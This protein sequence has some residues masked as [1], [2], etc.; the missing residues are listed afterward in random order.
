MSE[1]EPKRVAPMRIGIYGGA[2]DPPHLAHLALAQ[3]AVQQ[4]ELDQL[5]ALPTGHAWHKSRTLTLP[6]HRIAMVRLAFAELEQ[7]RVD[8]R[9][10]QRS[11][12][13]YTLDTLLA[14]KAE[15]PG[16]ELFLLMGG[17]QLAA[18]PHWHRYEEILQIAT[19]LVALRA[20]SMP[21]NG[22]KDLKNQGKINKSIIFSTIFMPASPISATQIRLLIAA[23]QPIDH[24]VKPTVARYIAENRLYSIT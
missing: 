7:A 12:P 13:T 5:I 19:L 17:D 3:A 11:G 1:A 16:S 24:L 22:Q 21:A 23:K 10:T 6:K 18:F 14:L 2:F 20:D 9:E 4:Y 8:I 15:N